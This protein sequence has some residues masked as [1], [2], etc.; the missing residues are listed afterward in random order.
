MF[1]MLL[2]A[3][4][5]TARAL[6]ASVAAALLLGFSLTA[7]PAGSARAENVL[8]GDCLRSYGGLSCAIRWGEYG[9]PYIRNVPKARDAEEDAEFAKHDRQWV[10]R[11]RPVILPDEVGVSRYHYASPGCEFGVND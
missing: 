2:P 1:T 4:T 5:G 10:A 11:C 3:V 9:N 8:T 7:M 6:Q